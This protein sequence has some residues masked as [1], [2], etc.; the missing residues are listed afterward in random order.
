[1]TVVGI[2]ISNV[3]AWIYMQQVKQQ[4]LPEDEFIPARNALW[5]MAFK[6]SYFSSFTV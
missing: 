6:V 1:V 5:Q 3:E 2:G 4:T